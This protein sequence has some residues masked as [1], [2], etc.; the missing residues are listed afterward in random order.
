MSTET[1]DIA[2]INLPCRNIHLIIKDREAD[3]ERYLTR[4]LSIAMFFYCL[5]HEIYDI[6]QSRYPELPYLKEIADLDNM[7][8]DVLAE[9]V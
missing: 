9:A 3:F 7:L 5:N 1:G 4:K 6:L 8:K 2:Y